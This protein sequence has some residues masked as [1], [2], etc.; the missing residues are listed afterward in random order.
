MAGKET[1]RV[2]AVVERMGDY[3]YR[4]SGRWCFWDVK[5]ERR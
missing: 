1:E 3:T 5:E 4:T 2:G